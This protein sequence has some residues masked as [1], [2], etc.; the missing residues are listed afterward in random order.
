MAADG[1]RLLLALAAVL[2]GGPAR[3]QAH[4]GLHG[5][6]D[7]CR[8]HEREIYPSLQVWVR[9]DRDSGVAR[10]ASACTLNVEAHTSGFDA[11]AYADA[12]GVNVSLATKHFGKFSTRLLRTTFSPEKDKIYVYLDSWSPWTR[13]VDPLF[14]NG[15]GADNGT[16]PN[17]LLEVLETARLSVEV[18]CSAPGFRPDLADPLETHADPD[19]LTLT[20]THDRKRDPGAVEVDLRVDERCVR[21]AYVKVVLRDACFQHKREMPLFH[22][23]EGVHPADKQLKSVMPLQQ[24]DMRSCTLTLNGGGR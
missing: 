11:H 6:E 23:G 9:V 10:N 5:G 12:A 22:F 16:D 17:L 4:K 19:L 13:Y 18:G 21:S 3:A 1:L 15:S 24:Q 14:R 2:G 7:F 8:A 20:D